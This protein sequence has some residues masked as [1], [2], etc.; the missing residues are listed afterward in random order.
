MLNSDT[1]SNTTD[2]ESY[3]FKK[4]IKSIHTEY[5]INIWS[6]ATVDV[7]SNTYIPW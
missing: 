2:F 3:G 4:N 6:R 1:N 5:D 7:Y